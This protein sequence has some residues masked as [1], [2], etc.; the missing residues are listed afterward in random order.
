MTADEELS[1]GCRFIEEGK[2]D[3]ARK[4]FLKM[5]RKSIPEAQFNLAL[6]YQDGKGVPR[7]MKKAAK[8]YTKAADNGMDE[9]LPQLSSKKMQELWI[10]YSSFVM[11]F[12]WPR[13]RKEN[14]ETI[15]RAINEHCFKNFKSIMLN[16]IK[17]F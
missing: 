8:W 9:A 1:K 6:M 15:Y 3:E 4:I 2:F 13:I 16:N 12:L 7:S 11:L 17:I 5:A 14:M 10:H